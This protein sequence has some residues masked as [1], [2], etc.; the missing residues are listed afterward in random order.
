MHWFRS[1]FHSLFPGKLLLLINSF[2]CSSKPYYTCMHVRHEP[3]TFC[4]TISHILIQYFTG[5]IS[6]V[7]HIISAIFHFTYKLKYCRVSGKTFGSYF[8]AAALISVVNM[9]DA[10]KTY[11]FENV[12]E[13]KN[14][15]LFF[16]GV[17]WGWAW[18]R[19]FYSIV[20]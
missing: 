13:T 12:I 7:R 9:S 11:A 3:L 5:S 10:R 20:E 6:N 2:Q 1:D 8:R 17:G 4:I 18:G 16:G 19:V 15:I 14:P